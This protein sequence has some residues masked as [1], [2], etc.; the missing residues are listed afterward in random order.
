[1]S[2]Q[3]TE[4]LYKKNAE[5]MLGNKE[6]GEISLIKVK[7]KLSLCLIKH[8]AMKMYWGVEV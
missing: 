3:E 4:K 2:E 8:H 6:G 5:E 1:M 7:I